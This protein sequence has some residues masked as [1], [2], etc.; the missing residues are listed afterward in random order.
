[1]A[2]LRGGTLEKQ[3]KDAFHRLLKPTQRHGK[4]DHLT[5]SRALGA[6]REMYLNDFKK[7]LEQ[8][9]YTGKMNEWMGDKRTMQ[10]FLKSRINGLSRK[11]AVNYISGFSSLLKGLKEVNITINDGG[12]RVIEEMREYAKSMEKIDRRMDRAI[13]NVEKTLNKLYS[14]DFNTGVLAEVQIKLGLR[15]SEAYELVQNFKQ[16]Y[17]PR[18]NIISGIKGKGNHT[19]IDKRISK[20]LAQR[21]KA[22][23]KARLPNHDKYLKEIKE[24]TGNREAVAHDFRYTFAKQKYNELKQQGKT[25]KQA[26]REVSREL[27]HH[28]ENITKYYLKG[29]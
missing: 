11:S 8:N 16:Y 28:R 14:R 20:D 7:H 1:M 17:N 26:L 9:N 22:V 29:A 25:E 2:N 3:V 21:I 6:K 4:S 27:N 23:T 15:T 13:G 10:E 12:I 19:Y 5:H 24:V 18:E